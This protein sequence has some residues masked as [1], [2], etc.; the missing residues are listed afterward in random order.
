MSKV[1]KVSEVSEVS[2]ESKVSEGSVSV[3]K[4]LI[5]RSLV[6]S[7]WS[8]AAPHDASLTRRRMKIVFSISPLYC[9]GLIYQARS[10]PSTLW[11]LMNRS[12]D[13]QTGFDESN[14]EAST[15]DSMYEGRLFS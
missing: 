9:R 3:G 14:H 10:R 6:I 13:S 7:H 1:S 11:G 15:I 4:C 12:G 8:L 2:E 5:E